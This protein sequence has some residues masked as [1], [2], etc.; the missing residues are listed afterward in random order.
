MPKFDEAGSFSNGV[1]RV[2]VSGQEYYIND[3]GESI[4]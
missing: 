4:F 3:R 1:A 2:E